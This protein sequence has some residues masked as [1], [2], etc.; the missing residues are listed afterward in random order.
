M[1]AH[2]LLFTYS[3]HEYDAEFAQALK[4][5]QKGYSEG[6]ITPEGINIFCNLFGIV[7]DDKGGYQLV[8]PARFQSQALWWSEGLQ[9]LAGHLTILKDSTIGPPKWQRNSMSIA[10]V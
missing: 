7:P 2:R 10:V 5:F 3:K 8:D 6:L 9:A 4:D 1:I